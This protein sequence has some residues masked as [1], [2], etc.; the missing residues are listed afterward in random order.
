M[1]PENLIAE[2]QASIDASIDEVWDALTN[3]ATIKKYMFGTNVTSE[4][5]EGSKIV[6]KGEWK[7]K[8][9]EDHGVI[10]QFKPKRLIEYTHFSPMMGKPDIPENYHTVT[11][12][13]L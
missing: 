1:E 9:Y 10:V 5:K 7:G 2:A 8:P 12:E 3:P 13:L 6:W 4:W 11:I